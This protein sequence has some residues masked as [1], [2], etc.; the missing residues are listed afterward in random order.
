M[1]ISYVK[2][3][4]YQ[5]KYLKNFIFMNKRKERKKEKFHFVNILLYRQNLNFQSK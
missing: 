5:R 3:S 4:F 1:D 2:K